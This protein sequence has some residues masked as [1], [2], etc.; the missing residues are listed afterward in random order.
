MMKENHKP[1]EI[2]KA[3]DKS[4]KPLVISHVLPDGDN[5]GS[6]IAMMRY[7]KAEGKEVTAVIN[8]DMPPYYCFLEGAEEL[9]PAACLSSGDYDCV[10]C[11]DM[12]GKNRAGNVW[13]AVEGNPVIINIDH[14][15]GNDCFADYNY[16]EPDAGSA[17][18]IIA[19]LL[20]EWGAVIDKQV[21]EALFT[22]IMTD[23]GCFTFP[24][25]SAETMRTAAMLLES[26]PD[27]GKIRE[28]VLE[29]VSFLR[30]KILGIVLNRAVLECDGLFCH[31][32]VTISDMEETGASESDFE[33]IVNEL[34]SVSGVQVAVFSRESRPGFVKT[35]FRGRG[36]AD[37]SKI[38][39]LFGGGGHKLAAGCCFDDNLEAA[40][41]KLF[42]AVR[43]YLE[44]F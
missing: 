37:V 17:A 1:S 14:H 24:S 5:V 3:V 31:S 26:H 22:G 27:L 42:A 39:A 18:E 23:T 36:G 32:S 8:G 10:I 20:A 7:L 40:E 2:K 13:D 25:T 11:L 9:I 43:G 41:E 35:S 38:A 6:V 30:K 29:N 28:Q 33:G 16:V 12:S 4:R 34:L 21:A 19:R 15:Q 44:E